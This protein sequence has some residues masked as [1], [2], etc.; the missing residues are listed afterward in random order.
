MN[1]RKYPQAPNRLRRRLLSAMLGAPIV[2]AAGS[3]ALL[4]TPRD[5]RTISFSHLHTG[6]KLS[7]AYMDASEYQPDALAAINHLL[8]DFRT[9]ELHPIDPAVLDFV[10]D[11]QNAVGSS[12]TVEVISAYRSPATNE[13]LRKSSTGVAKKSYHMKGQALDI[14]LTDVSTGTARR[15]ANQLRRGGVGYYSASDFLHVDVGPVRDW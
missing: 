11:I 10:V 1:A 15:A 7:V 5:S 14:R 8:R 13:M 12:G 9:D 2:Y 3:S 4:A 6:E